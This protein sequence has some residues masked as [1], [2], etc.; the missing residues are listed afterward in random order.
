MN[1]TIGRYPC[2]SQAERD[3]AGPEVGWAADRIDSYIEPED[4]SW[5]LFVYRDGSPLLWTRRYPEGGVIGPPI[6]RD[7]VDA[8]YAR[9]GEDAVQEIIESVRFGEP[10]QQ[11]S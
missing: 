9:F 3:G 2:P 5:I 1:I 4:R 7:F 6:S 8:L 11:P 10:D